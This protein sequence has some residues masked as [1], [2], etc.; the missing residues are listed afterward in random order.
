MN[1]I[2]SYNKY[3]RKGISNKVI[4]PPTSVSR[5][6]HPDC[7]TGAS[8]SVLVV[9]H[10]SPTTN[11]EPLHLLTSLKNGVGILLLI[12]I[13]TRIRLRN[14]SQG[15]EAPCNGVHNLL[16]ILILAMREAAY[17]RG[18]GRGGV[19]HVLHH[20]EER[21]HTME[22]AAYSSS[23]P[24]DGGGGLLLAPPSYAGGQGVGHVLNCEDEGRSSWFTPHLL[25]TM[26][27]TKYSSSL[28]F[29]P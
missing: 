17:L 19:R 16:L 28:Q 22:Y 14:Q 18:R 3:L 9:V 8:P 4:H 27:Y 20:K 1:N 11:R 5:W 2:R 23:P 29:A 13:R 21:R 15:G 7:R 25:L 6:H 24:R 10:L 26:E 12:L